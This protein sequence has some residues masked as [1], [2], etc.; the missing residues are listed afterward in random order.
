M[1]QLERAN[2]ETFAVERRSH[3]A[4]TTDAYLNEA[5]VDDIF[6]PWLGRTLEM[7]TQRSSLSV[8]YKMHGDPSKSGANFG[9]SI[10]HVEQGEDGW[11]HV[12]FDHISAWR[13]SDFD[14]NRYEIDYAVVEQELKA[15]VDAFVPVEVSFDQFN[16]VHSIQELRRH[17]REQRHPKNVSVFER[18][19]TRALNWEVAETFKTSLGL[20][21]VHA[22]YFEL[23]EQ[24]LKFLQDIGGKVAHQTSGPVQ[25]KDVADTMMILVH[26]L[27]GDQM[28]ARAAGELA[29]L[30]LRMSQPAG[31][32]A[33]PSGPHAELSSFA[34]GS[35]PEAPRNPARGRHLDARGRG[36]ASRRRAQLF[37]RR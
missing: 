29:S 17:V 2:P 20:G 18:T 14:Q 10:A 16:S 36:A 22:P 4:A 6:K 19:A 8:D 23:A 34:R 12:V 28:K 32:S 25:T 13:P 31:Q 27:I 30:P 33:A 37:G 24:E 5:R 1:K 15:Y 11:D 35:R 7:Q 9:L 3:W 21:L 26:A